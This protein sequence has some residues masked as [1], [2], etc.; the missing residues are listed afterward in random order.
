LTDKDLT[1]EQKYA[2]MY[3]F[4]AWA[5]CF[6]FYELARDEKSA[7]PQGEQRLHKIVERNTESFKE[8]RMI[9]EWYVFDWEDVKEFH[10]GDSEEAE[11]MVEK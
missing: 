1:D 3:L 4:D 7:F 11:N 9:P 6:M 2:I 8:R 10:H 5:T